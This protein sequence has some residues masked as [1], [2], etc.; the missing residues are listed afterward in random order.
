MSESEVHALL[1]EVQS[2]LAFQEDTIATLNNVLAEQ[3]RELLR[4]RRQL[5]L[6]KQQQDEHAA[7][8]ADFPG[9]AQGQERPPHY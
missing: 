4:L 5:E 9:G 7:T 8:L 6:L 1:H 2:Q 3:Q